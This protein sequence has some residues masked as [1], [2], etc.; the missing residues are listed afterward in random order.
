MIRPS[1]FIALLLAA[2]LLAG[3]L[4][5][6]RLRSAESDAETAIAQLRAA[7]A[8]AHE[9][10]ALRAQ[11]ERIGAAKRAPE[12]VLARINA[13]LRDTALG[14]G[15]VSNYREHSDTELPG[16]TDGPRYR[17]QSIQF[18]LSPIELPDLGRFLD[19][20]RT[21]E[22]LWTPTNLELTRVGS[23]RSRNT[24]SGYAATI[25][26]AATYVDIGSTP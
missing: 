26:I 16:R 21:S 4:A 15:R 23:Q 7:Q 13:A 22:P 12:D 6:G 18:T 25:T 24:Q 3:A 2:M 11:S 20:W 5:T 1:Y 19:H 17:R 14:T 10:F 9:V 8:D